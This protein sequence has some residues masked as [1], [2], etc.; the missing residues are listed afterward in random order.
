M[1]VLSPL[2]GPCEWREH[3]VP[4]R[5]LPPDRSYDTAMGTVG[6]LVSDVRAELGLSREQLARRTG[7]DE[8]DIAALERDE[9]SLG[10]EDLA[11]VLLVMGR[12]PVLTANGDEIVATEPIALEFDP[13][14]LAEA[15]GRTMS[16]RLERSA[17]WNRFAA[18]LAAAELRPLR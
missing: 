9:V 16:E 8:A 2:R 18:Q 3:R 12:R 1:T 6:Q 7:R 11:V 13:D 5:R 17:Q 10:L 14:D 15:A 4:A